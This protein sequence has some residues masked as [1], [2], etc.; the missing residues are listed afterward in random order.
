MQKKQHP[1][2]CKRHRQIG[3]LFIPPTPLFPLLQLGRGYDPGF[4]KHQLREGLASYKNASNRS[5]GRAGG[6]GGRKKRETEEN[7]CFQSFGELARRPA[8]K[9]W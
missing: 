9:Q 2:D 7:S 1:T 8:D 3:L 6:G 4:R 5:S